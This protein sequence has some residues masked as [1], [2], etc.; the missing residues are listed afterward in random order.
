MIP[1]PGG[2]VSILLLFP[3]IFFGSRIAGAS[4]IEMN[5]GRRIRAGIVLGI[6]ALLMAI[7]PPLGPIA[8]L[9]VL[10]YGI[11][12]GIQIMRQG[13]GRRRFPLGI[14]VIACTFFALAD[15]VAS[16]GAYG[17]HLAANEASTVGSLRRLSSAEAKFS[18]PSGL[19]LVKEPRYGTIEDLRKRRLI[20]YDAQLATAHSGYVFRQAVEP[21]KKQFLFYAVP[22]HLPPSSSEPGWVHF[23]PGFSLYFHV[24]HRDKSHGTGARS[25]AVDETGTIRFTSAPVS[26][27]VQREEARHWDPL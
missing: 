11:F 12:C 4:P 2:I 3:I 20:D 14:V 10:F 24:L 26:G 22:E 23:L 27:L 15:Y 21:E 9:V 6:C 8:F 7:L 13:E 18:D 17:N 19:E 1:E 16:F 25:F 5:R